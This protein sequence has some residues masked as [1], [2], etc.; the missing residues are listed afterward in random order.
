M[1]RHLVLYQKQIL[2]QQR[3]VLYLLLIIF[4]LMPVA[5]KMNIL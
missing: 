1:K 3:Y 4:M 2:L 5:A